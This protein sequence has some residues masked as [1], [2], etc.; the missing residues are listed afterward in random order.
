MKTIKQ[1]SRRGAAMG[2]IVALLLTPT[3]SQARRV[4]VEGIGISIRAA[5]KA[6]SYKDDHLDNTS[7]SGGLI[8]PKKSLPAPI[9]KAMEY[10]THDFR[11][12]AQ[13]PRMDE[14][15]R[16]KAD[17]AGD[18]L[19]AMPSPAAIN[20]GWT[21]LSAGDKPDF[22]LDGAKRNGDTKPDTN[23]PYWF[24]KHPYAAPNIWLTL[25]ANSLKTI[26]PPFVFAKKDELYWENPP[27]FN[28]A[29]AVIIAVKKPL[30]VSTLANPV[31]LV[32]PNG[33][34][35][36]SITGAQSPGGAT[37]LWRS[38][39][40]GAH[41]TV[42]QD[43]FALNRH[44]IFEHRGSIYLLGMNTKGE[45]DTRIY[46]SSD[47][48]KT[49]TTNAWKGLGGEDAPSQVA[50]ANGRIW[51]AAYAFDNAG[52]KGS[53]F[54]SAPV[55]AD[56]MQPSSWTLSVPPL[57][58]GTYQLANGQQFKQGNEGSLLKSKEGILYNL[59]RDQ[60]YRHEDGWKPG[61]STMQPDLSDLTKT[62]WNP[63]YAGPRLPGNENGKCTALY[64]AVSDKYWALTSGGNRRQLN[65]YSAGSEGGK[66]DD[67]RFRAT[68][69]EGTSFNEGFNYP[70]IQFDGDD[71]IFVSR[72]AWE[73]HRGTATRWHNGN[74]FT[75]HRIKNFRQLRVIP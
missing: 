52:H 59:G 58:W 12:A 68:V 73:T 24:Y 9:T 7:F 2:A 46:K 30:P 13:D 4:S 45:G 55:D 1:K 75:F 33:D 5:D 3:A 53:G 47:N 60:V 44:S 21:R 72:T 39:D 41:W 35:L 36:A 50:V 15:N 11:P 20:N 37:G 19:I 26:H 14:I 54:Y 17:A 42:V 62:K 65:L 18:L 8:F 10:A 34:Y 69:L 49:W 66:I 23:A 16:V 70:F 57:D 32:M 74:L 6:Y 56:L 31:L 29:N 67:F 22:Y 40:K 25:P 64:D 43:G 71:L 63:D 38:T 27:A 28:Q 61:I 51:K 48:G